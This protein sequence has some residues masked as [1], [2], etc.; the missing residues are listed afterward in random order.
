[1]TDLDL[2][3]PYQGFQYLEK[4][5]LAEL[6]SP[7][8]NIGAVSLIRLIA[9]AADPVSDLAVNITNY[10]SKHWLR[11]YA[12]GAEGDLPTRTAPHYNAAI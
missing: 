11:R 6:D 9:D 4:P 3:F 10:E 1:M 12:V 5:F 2:G 7:F 8:F